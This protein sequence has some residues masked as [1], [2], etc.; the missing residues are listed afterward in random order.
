MLHT[1][2]QLTVLPVLLVRYH[3]TFGSNTLPEY[4]LMENHEIITPVTITDLQ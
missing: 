2:Y 3:M 4:I 1:K